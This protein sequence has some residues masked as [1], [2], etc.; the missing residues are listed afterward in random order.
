MKTELDTLRER[1]AG[2]IHAADPSAV[3]FSPKQAEA[4]W[5]AFL[6]ALAEMRRWGNGDTAAECAKAYATAPKLAEYFG[7]ES[8]SFGSRVLAPLAKAGKVRVLRKDAMMH[9]T[10]K[11]L[12]VRYNIADVERALV[13]P[14]TD[15]NGKKGKK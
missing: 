6:D 13:N 9:I 14:E 3:V 15:A 5:G 2:A 1:G 7:Y 10:G 4:M 11:P 12:G 8:R